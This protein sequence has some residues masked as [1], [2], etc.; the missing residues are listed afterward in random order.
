MTFGWM[1]YPGHIDLVNPDY[2]LVRWIGEGAVDNVFIK[3]YYLFTLPALIMVSIGNLRRFL[4][5]VVI[6][7]ILVLSFKFLRGSMRIEWYLD[8][9]GYF[10][11]LVVLSLILKGFYPELDL[12][13]KKYRLF[14]V[15]W[16]LTGTYII[17]YSINF[18]SLRYLSVLLPLL[19]A[20]YFSILYSSKYKYIATAIGAT[21][22]ITVFILTIQSD[23][24]IFDISSNWQKEL[25]CRSEAVH[26]IEMSNR[27]TIITDFLTAEYLRIESLSAVERVLIVD[28]NME[29]SGYEVIKVHRND[30]SCRVIK[31]DGIERLRKE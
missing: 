7:L 29:Q 10:G 25:D 15:A 27:D 4:V 26:L 5:S 9:L 11:S 31:S 13:S 21:T 19:I 14:L 2:K 22:M 6:A 23:N 24:R 8:F 1:L 12:L 20:V 17:F 18:S 16:I 28:S 30:T 3:P